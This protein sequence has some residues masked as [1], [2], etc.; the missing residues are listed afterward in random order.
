[1]NGEASALDP[2]LHSRHEFSALAFDPRA[3]CLAS[4][5]PVGMGSFKL[6]DG[7]E[8]L[9]DFLFF[10]QTCE[11]LV[12]FNRIHFW[13]SY[14]PILAPKGFSLL[15]GGKVNYV[16]NRSYFNTL[17]SISECYIEEFSSNVLC[18]TARNFRSLFQTCLNLI[19]PVLY[20]A[21]FLYLCV[22][23]WVYL[24]KLILSGLEDFP[25]LLRSFECFLSNNPPLHSI[26]WA[27]H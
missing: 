2:L 25:S 3:T 24:Y 11:C 22:G 15:L 14:L 1:M 19:S 12:K 7:V 20:Y 9:G 6:T 18:H 10:L 23:W 26:I 5:A 8:D 4:Q 21:V 16:L 13:N 27:A 17:P